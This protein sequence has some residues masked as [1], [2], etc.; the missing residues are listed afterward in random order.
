MKTFIQTLFAAAAVCVC[1]IAYAQTNQPITRA[2]VRAELTALIQQGYKPN[3]DDYP[4]TLLAAQQRLDEQRDS[5]LGRERN[6]NMMK[7]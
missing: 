7:Q 5:N 2:Q 6:A 4:I 3:R 1:G